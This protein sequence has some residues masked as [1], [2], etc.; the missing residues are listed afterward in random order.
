MRILNLIYTFL[1]YSSLNSRYRVLKESVNKNIDKL[2][3]FYRNLNL[4]N[5]NLNN[6]NILNSYRYAEKIKKL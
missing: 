1:T 3:D 2:M 6:Y 5:K 4:I